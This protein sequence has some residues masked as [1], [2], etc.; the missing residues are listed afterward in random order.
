M[1]K[2]LQYLVYSFLI[3]S[4][5]F[6]FS[7][8]N[9]PKVALVLSGGGAKGVAH[10][11]TLQI[12]DSL[13]IVPDLIIGTSMGAVVGGF[14]SMGYSGDSIAVITKDANWDE[15]LGG[16]VALSD[17]SVEE[18]SEFN[19]YMVDFDWV[20]GKPKVSSS[21]LNDQNLREF[22]SIY[23]RPVYRINDFDELP[24]PYRAM[25]TDIV[26][27]NEL[28]L[29][30]GS[31][32]LAMRASMSIPSVFLPVPY[33]NT[34]LVDGGVLNNFPT[35]VAKAM[36]ADVIIGSDV[37]GGLDPKEKLDKMTNLIFQT[38]MITSLKK[39]PENQKLCDIL[40]DHTPNLTYST[41]DFNKSKMIYEEGKVAAYKNMDAFVALANKLKNYKQRDHTI[42]DV[43]TKFII[44]DFVYKNISEDNLD[45]VKSRANLIP[46]K[47]YTVEEIKEG[48]N[49]TMGTELFSQ[50][51]FSPIFEEDKILLEIEGFEKSKLQTKGSIHF[52]THRGVGLIINYTGRNL[53]GEAS[54]FLV[55]LDIAEQP[56]F[57]V[58]YQNNFG[59]KKEWWWSSEVLGQSLTQEFYYEGVR[60]E[61]LDNNFFQIDNEFNKNINSLNSYVGLGL[62]YESTNYEPANKAEI[63]G[64]I[65]NMEKY[66]FKN[67][68]INVHFDYN[69]F[70]R[71]FFPT[72]GRFLYAEFSRSLY[73]H[74]NFEFSDNSE[75]DVIGKTNGYSKFNFS[76]GQR[77]GLNEKITGILGVSAGFT[78]LD[79]LQT[80]DYSFIDYGTG[81][82]YF[83]GGNIIRPRKDTYVFKGLNSSEL[84]VTQFMMLNLGLQANIFGDIMLTPHL[85]I[86]SVGN[87]GFSD[88]IKDAFSPKGNWQ[89]FDEASLL[90]SSGLTASYNSFLGPVNFDISWVN[91]INKVRIFFSIGIPLSR[92]N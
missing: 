47:E 75:P 52:D 29:D 85:N 91:K 66:N 7:Q 54:R 21:I 49:R 84:F 14:Y 38:S 22:L 70:N 51:T 58:H 48:V 23:A 18:K 17:I 8:N 56:S 34:L 59:N 13:G 11:P 86:A 64:N 45:I 28:L 37:G 5:F 60:A 71:V 87:T 80:D 76:F 26:N 53:I 41:G 90:V 65:F 31:I 82:A 69:T 4:P 74:V 63:N 40:I 81:G 55:T 43:P 78:F 32:I 79:K 77:F 2:F 57:R 50:I 3:I 19:R 1:S 39:N 12:L 20:E 33:N 42:P 35:D 24:I 36:G 73:H 89:Y 15:L 68:E 92:S 25:T 62:N 30:K 83:L 6:L 88:Y 10:I 44:S 72:K 9:K 46:G 27:G 16:K 67:I 61:E